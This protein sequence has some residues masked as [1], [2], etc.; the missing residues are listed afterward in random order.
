MK[1]ADEKVAEAKSTY[2]NPL[3]VLV[4]NGSGSYE[5]CEAFSTEDAVMFKRTKDGM[6]WGITRKA[7]VTT[8]GQHEKDDPED[9]NGTIVVGYK[10]GDVVKSIRIRSRPNN[11]GLYYPPG[12]PEYAPGFIAMALMI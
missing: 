5:E 8:M 6:V 12:G 11:Y 2:G 3:I 9:E 7:I 1:M 4:D 10:D